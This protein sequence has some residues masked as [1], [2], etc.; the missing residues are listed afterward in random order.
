MTESPSVQ[1]TVKIKLRSGGEVLGAETVMLKDSD[2]CITAV[3]DNDGTLT[4]VPT[5]NIAS[6]VLTGDLAARFRENNEV[7]GDEPGSY[8]QPPL[9]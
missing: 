4:V 9:R 6:V 2:G 1:G 5:D 3:A 8:A 7:R